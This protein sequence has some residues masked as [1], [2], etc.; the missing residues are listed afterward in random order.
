MQAQWRATPPFGDEGTLGARA[1]C[2]RSRRKA[3]MPKA[4]F[5]PMRLA[6]HARARCPRPQGPS[7]LQGSAGALT[8]AAD[9]KK[10]ACRRERGQDALAPRP[11]R[12]GPSLPWAGGAFH[13]ADRRACPAS[14]QC[15]LRRLARANMDAGLGGKASCLPCAPAGAPSSTP[16]RE[17]ILPTRPQGRAPSSRS[18]RSARWRAQGRQNAFPPG[19]RG[20]GGVA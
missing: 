12:R 3:R 7:P 6:A 4:A 13:R 9:L 17:G 15:A 10:R 1:S 16:R 19:R 2:P 14:N 5:E 8:P 20:L 18:T 11:S